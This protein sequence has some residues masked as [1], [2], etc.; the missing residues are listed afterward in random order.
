THLY[1]H[2]PQTSPADIA[3]LQTEL[4]SWIGDLFFT[5]RLP[6]RLIESPEFR[7]LIKCLFP[8]FRHISRHRLTNALLPEKVNE[9]MTPLLQG[10][11][12]SEYLAITTDECSRI[13]GSKFLTLLSL[14]AHYIDEDWEYK[15]VVVATKQL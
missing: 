11:R 10:A 6:F 7:A 14:S 15:E 2:Q 1:P 9:V 13:V 5:H 8:S 4:E 12:R 3:K